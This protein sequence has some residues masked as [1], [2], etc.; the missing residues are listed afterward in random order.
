MRN[1]LAVI[2]VL[3]S[4]GVGTVGTGV[5]HASSTVVSDKITLVGKLVPGSSPSN[6]TFGPKKCSLTSDSETPIFA[7]QSSGGITLL[8][9]GGSGFVNVNGAD[10][11]I[12]WKFTITAASS[13][14]YAMH[15]KGTEQDNPEAGT[16][17]TPYAAV[18]TGTVTIVGSKMTMVAK[19]KELATQP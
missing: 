4:I 6:F 17:S 10:G 15:G 12:N 11:N 16:G 1:R 19:V 2:A 7:C 13:S 14:T 3:A 18:M 5:A 8:G 9:T